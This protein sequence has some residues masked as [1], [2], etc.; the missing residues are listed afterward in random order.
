GLVKPAANQ[1]PHF[2]SLDRLGLCEADHLPL[3][4]DRRTASSWAAAPS[5]TAPST[6]SSSSSLA[7]DCH[8]T[9][10]YR[11]FSAGARTLTAVAAACVPAC[12][13][14]GST[15]SRSLAPSEPTARIEVPCSRYA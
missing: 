14:A 4:V 13:A 2:P 7:T 6:K 3:S 8:G 15:T 10:W 9:G 1:R 12:A 11:A 5:T